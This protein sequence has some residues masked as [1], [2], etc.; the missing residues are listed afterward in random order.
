M[1]KWLRVF[2]CKEKTRASCEN[3]S[4]IYSVKKLHHSSISQATSKSQNKRSLPWFWSNH[5]CHQAIFLY[6]CIR[7]E[8]LFRNII[9]KM[10]HHIVARLLENVIIVSSDV[11]CMCLL[12]CFF[13]NWLIHAC[14]IH[15]WL[16]DSVGSVH[17]RLLSF[18]PTRCLPT[19]CVTSLE[20]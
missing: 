7:T 13:P 17:N 3:E 18:H 19:R 15:Y 20:L 8:P 10:S 4:N 16:S 1:F 11:N 6:F 12:Q 2:W 9:H 14:N 5:V